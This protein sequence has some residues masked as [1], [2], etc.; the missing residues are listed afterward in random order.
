MRLERRGSEGNL[1]K[2]GKAVKEDED[3]RARQPNM[4]FLDLSEN[5]M[6]DEGSDALLDALLC[7]TCTRMKALLLNKCNLNDVSGGEAL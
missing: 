7:G 3:E 1:R 2:L 4:S 6:G 5:D